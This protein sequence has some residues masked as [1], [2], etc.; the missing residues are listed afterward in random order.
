MLTFQMLGGVALAG[1]DRAEVDALLRQTKHLALLAYLALPRP[2]T[3]HRRD[4][5]LAIFWPE[6]DEARARTALRSALHLLRRHLGPD[7]VRNRGTG[8]VGIAPEALAT[9]VGRLRDAATAGRHAEVLA[10]YQGEFLPALHVDDA[11]DFQRW[12]DAERIGLRALARRSASA[13]AREWEQRGDLAE[14]VDAARRAA[15]LDPDDEGIARALIA[16]LDRVG[17]RAQAFA[18]YERHRT[19]LAAEFGARPSAETLAL[20]EAVRTRR[21]VGAAPTID[22]L[23]NTALDEGPIADA[24][25]P[26]APVPTTPPP[27]DP[28]PRV[29]VPVQPVDHVT[30]TPATPALARAR[31]SRRRYAVWGAAA[32]VAVVLATMLTPRARSHASPGGAHRATGAVPHVL[33]LPP[34]NAT[35]DTAQAYLA[36]GVSD[37]VARQLARLGSLAVSSSARAPWPPATPPDVRALGR[38]FGSTVLLRLSL[39]RVDGA[40]GDSLEVRPVLLDQASRTE[41]PL[42]P[43]RFAAADARD[44]ASAVT[45]EVVGAVFR[46]PEP[47]VPHPTAHP[48]DPESYRLTLDGWHQFFSFFDRRGARARF[49]AAIRRDPL[50]ARAW[51]G[52]T[53]SWAAQL[54]TDEVPADEAYVNAAA[55]AERAIA[56]D[57]LE[58]TAWADLAL[59]HMARARRFAAGAPFL[60]R[61]ITVDPSNPEVYLIAAAMY[62]GM[63][64]WD[65]V[66]AEVR[67]ARALDPLNPFYLDKAAH[68]EVCADRP[69]AVLALADEGLRADSTSAAFWRYRILALSRLGRYD[70]A[71]AAWRGGLT[72]QLPPPVRAALDGATGAT[73]F[74]AAW[75]AQGQW[76]LARLRVAG[77]RGWVSPDLVAA[78]TVQAGDTAAGWRA[79]NARVPARGWLLYK[80]ACSEQFAEVRDTPQFAALVA[81]VGAVPEW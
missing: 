13:L 73:G 50:N 52:L 74:W 72:A 68:G 7:T 29:S 23:T 14:A 51:A 42:R 55:A 53:T 39:A 27:A 80:L 2:G 38:R 1:D 47:M 56:L 33:V 4:T 11:D 45:A 62:R 69:A 63:H 67:R 75:R 65:D 30:A 25:L 15:A 5:L 18:A 32:G 61:A 16:L 49:E 20:V 41:H 17:D 31:P 57:S 46:V 64:R 54:A 8:E 36:T 70:E 9:D 66:R 34:E 37:D 78:A 26:R 44:A 28:A 19:H 48:V 6:L 71:I 24:P 3:W 40:V 35:H 10:C 22:T 77:A 60:R 76:E 59:V 81:R 58:G 79:L 21:T 43:T 12:L